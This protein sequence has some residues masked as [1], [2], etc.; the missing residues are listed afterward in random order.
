MHTLFRVRGKKWAM[1]AGLTC[2][3]CLQVGCIQSILA[4]IGATFF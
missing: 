1:L 2:G 3:T 4:I